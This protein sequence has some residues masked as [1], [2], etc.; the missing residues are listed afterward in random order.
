MFFKDKDGKWW[1]TIFNGPVNEKPAILPV[2][3]D[4]DGQ[5][6]LREVK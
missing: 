6:A 2:T 5:I 3:I 4:A 1:S